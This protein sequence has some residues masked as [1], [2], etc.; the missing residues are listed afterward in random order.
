MCADA[1]VVPLDIDVLR[2]D[3][4]PPFDPLSEVLAFFLT[5]LNRVISAAAVIIEKN[6]IIPR[7]KNCQSGMK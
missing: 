5:V 7:I 6:W 2:T 4:L 3:D 1:S